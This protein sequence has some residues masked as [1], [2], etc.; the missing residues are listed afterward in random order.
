M[1][2]SVSIDDEALARAQD[3]TSGCDCATY[4][5]LV[6][7]G[8]DQFLGQVPACLSQSADGN[9]DK[10][11]FLALLDA[12]NEAARVE[13]V[14]SAQPEL[15]LASK[16]AGASLPTVTILSPTSG[17]EIGSRLLVQWAGQDADPGDVLVYTVSYTPDNGS[18]W[19][20]LADQV[21][22]TTLDLS[23]RGL[24]GGDS[25]RIRIAVSDGL[26][27]AEALSAPFLL[28]RHP[29]SAAIL[30]ETSR[31]LS[32]PIAQAFASFGET[33]VLHGRGYDDEDG[34]LRDASMSW[35]ILTPNPFLP[36]ITAN[37]SRYE[38]RDLTP[39]T[40][41]I[42][43]TAVD[44]DANSV[45]VT[46]YLIVEPKYLQTSTLPINL[47]GVADDAAYEEDTH[48]IQWTYADGSRIAARMVIQGSALYVAITGLTNGV[49]DRQFAAVCI[50]PNDSG[51]LRPQSND[52]R[53]QVFA[54]GEIAIYSGDGSTFARE[55]TPN[56]LQ[57]RVSRGSET[58][59]AEL[60]IELSRLV[61]WVDLARFS[62]GHYHRHFSG[63]DTLWPQPCGWDVPT[64]WGRCGRGLNPNDPID[65][66]GDGLPDGWE[67]EY[68][69]GTDRDGTGDFDGD[70]RL[71]RDEW[72][73]GFHPANP[74]LRQALTILANPD[75]SRLLTW[76]SQEGRSYTILRAVNMEGF[77][78][79]A[80]AI[81]SA[82]QQTTWLD[83]ET[84]SGLVVYRLK[85]EY[86]R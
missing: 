16:S 47:D 25:C 45:Q 72:V 3:F 66:D 65:V 21:R 55:A 27:I 43:L 14:P 44:V 63:D 48:P 38:M 30:F 34:S 28:A 32:G 60:A 10:R 54:D 8:A 75:G 56:G 33:V 20:V 78:P 5:L 83:A 86:W 62:I 19:Q 6:F 12:V 51:D 59:S 77:I 64:S 23:T 68:F 69:G 70:G 31:G 57:A 2:E 9:N 15:I 50:D 29:P 71:D 80:T 76:N 85:V 1:L 53:F 84:V 39:G 17:E 13:L 7:D 52:L 26:H 74:G 35:Q 22:V 67:T 58:W 46:A 73:D 18:N 4:R 49:N 42:Q 82:G 40:Y 79:I 41:A 81:P 36:V 11:L 37:G 61:G 24:I